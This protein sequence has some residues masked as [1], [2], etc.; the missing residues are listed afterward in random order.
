MPGELKINGGGSH[1]HFT[2]DSISGSGEPANPGKSGD[3]QGEPI[4]NNITG[5]GRFKLTLTANAAELVLFSAE[6]VY[7][8]KGQG[9]T[10]MAGTYNGDWK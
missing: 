9:R 5:G 8:Y 6:R 10:D 4:P 7:E 1:M 2:V 3:F